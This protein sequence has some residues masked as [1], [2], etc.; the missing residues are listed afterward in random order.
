[1]FS[2]FA[3]YV[4][5]FLL[6]VR[7]IFDILIELWNTFLHSSTHIVVLRN[8]IM[9]IELVYALNS[10]KIVVLLTHNNLLFIEMIII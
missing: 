4:E 10:S 3:S 5:G 1:M 7:L 6:N 9:I 8:L 2:E